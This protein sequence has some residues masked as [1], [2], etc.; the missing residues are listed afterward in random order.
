[1]LPAGAV[2][3]ESF[4]DYGVEEEFR[5]FAD[6]LPPEAQSYLPE[7][8]LSGSDMEQVGEAVAQMTTWDY[9]IHVLERILSV[10]WGTALKIISVVTGILLLSAAAQALWQSFGTESLGKVAGMGLTFLLFYRV[11]QVL[12]G[13]L[14]RVSGFLDGLQTLITSLLPMLAALNVLGGNTATAAVQNGGLMVFLGVVQT[15]CNRTIL[16]LTGGCLAMALMGA[17][18]PDNAFGYVMGTVKKGYTRVLGFLLLVL[19]FVMSAQTA[20]SAASDSLGARTA[21]FMAVQLIPLT[22]G[23]VGESLRTLASGVR[24]LKSTVG[25]GAVAVMFILLLPVGVNL[26]LTRFA[27][28]ICAGL[29]EL[30]GCRREKK[31][32]EEFGS[33]CGML[34]AVVALCGTLFVFS[35]VL[36]VR[37]A[38]AVGG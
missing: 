19:G 37:A 18:S 33:V 31:L 2:E 14:E 9:F 12:W 10:E 22:G 20:L 4:S 3:G 15:L 21:K 16:P 36:F 28:G 26:L 7:A 11:V 25:V 17:V 29:A 8:F 32:L 5:H 23:T 24:Y 27:L 38:V 1:M 30:L 6:G 34:L 35:M 13:L